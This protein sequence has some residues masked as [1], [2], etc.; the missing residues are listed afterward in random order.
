MTLKLMSFGY[1]YGLPVQFDTVLDM[2]CMEN[3]FW[4]PELRAM[5]GMD[6]PVRDYIFDNPNSAAYIG[7]LETMLSLQI[8][9]VQTRG[10]DEVSVAVG[11]TGG[12]HRSVAVTEH[13]AHVFRAAGI[14]V[15]VTHRDLRKTE[16]K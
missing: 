1:K 10:K 16:E 5:S 9:L 8:A 12:Q 13:L 6:A 14:A 3:P 4:V 15:E 11:C 2:R 7:S